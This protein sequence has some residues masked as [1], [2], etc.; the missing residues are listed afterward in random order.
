VYAAVAQV[1]LLEVEEAA[2]SEGVLREPDEAVLRE[3]EDLAKGGYES[4][5]YSDPDPGIL[6]LIQKEKN[7]FGIQDPWRYF[8]RVEK[9][10]WYWPKG[11]L[12]Q[13]L[14]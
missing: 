1:D 11:G 10:F 7:G 9:K 2:R 6:V 4:N 8:E 3:V 12:S 14:M 13:I 5:T